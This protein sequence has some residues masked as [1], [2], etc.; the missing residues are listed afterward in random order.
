LEN[1]AFQAG[2]PIVQ[3]LLAYICCKDGYGLDVDIVLAEKLL[4]GTGVL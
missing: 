3:Y 4:R 2:F 1:T